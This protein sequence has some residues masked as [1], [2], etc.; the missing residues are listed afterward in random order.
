MAEG[1]EEIFITHCTHNNE[2]HLYL[3]T[4]LSLACLALYAARQA[5]VLI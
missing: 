5:G 4:L 3:L 1:D 2:E